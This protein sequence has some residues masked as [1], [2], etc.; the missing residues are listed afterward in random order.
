MSASRNIV[1][2]A[3][4]ILAKE[5]EPN[6]RHERQDWAWRYG[7]L[8]ATVKQALELLKA[9]E[10]KACKACGGSG[11]KVIKLGKGGSYTTRTCPKCAAAE[12]E[13]NSQRSP[14]DSQVRNSG[15]AA[16]PEV[17]TRPCR[18]N[19]PAGFTGHWRDWHRGHGCE[20]DP[21]AKAASIC[22]RC[23]YMFADGGV[24]KC[25]HNQ[26]CG[27]CEDNHHAWVAGYE[28]QKPCRC[29]C[30]SGDRL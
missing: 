12:P 20:K 28:N 7:H 16:E 25:G 24:C 11:L 13:A 19:S 8:E 17:R 14:N 18:D 2:E 5:L 29:T 22:V 4:A 30:H 26:I 21:E 23:G 1:N 6:E 3:I 9:A 10:A 15:K 27:C